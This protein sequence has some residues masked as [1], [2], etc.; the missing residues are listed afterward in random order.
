MPLISALACKLVEV[1]DQIH[2]EPHSQIAGLYNK[3]TI[4]E[5]YR[6][7]YGVNREYLRIYEGSEMKFT[8]FDTDGNT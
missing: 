3:A 4:S 7:G 2:L 8:G 1:S 6:C 5:E